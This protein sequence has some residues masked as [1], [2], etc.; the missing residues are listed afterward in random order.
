MIAK[1]LKR[2]LVVLFIVIGVYP[3]FG[4]NNSNHT[5]ISGSVTCQGKGVKNVAVTDGISVVST[6][7]NG[8]YSISTTFDQSHIYYS[9]PANYETPIVDGIP[10][11]YQSVD[12]TK[13]AQVVNFK[14]EKSKRSQ[15]THAFVVW[16][17]PQVYEEAEFDLLDKVVDDLNQS[18]AKLTTSRSVHGICMGD[19]VFD[20]AQFF[21]KYKQQVAKTNIPFYQVIGNHDLDYNNRTN[22][23]SAKTYNSKFGPTYY[24]FN[25]GKIHYVVL[26]DVFYYGYTY[27]YMGYFDETQ[28]R[29]LERDLS[30]VKPGSTVVLSM[31]IPTI[32]GESEKAEKYSTTIANSVMNRSAFYKILAPFNAHL[33][34]GHSHTQWNTI[35]SPTLYEHTHA[36]ACAAWWQGELCVDGSPKGYTVYM[37][38]GDSLSWYFKGVG[39]DKSE[40]FKLYPAGSD[41]LYTDCI[42]ANVF[43]YDPSWQVKWLEDDKLMGEMLQYWGVDPTAKSMYPEGKNKKHSWLSYGETHHLFK[44]KMVNP[45][46]KISVEVIDRFGNKY[47]KT[48]M[49]DNTN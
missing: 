29:W 18:I 12:T 21:D 3:L 34:A 25:V 45:N 42:I 19:I 37:A 22:E 4:F 38:D 30:L 9:L 41:S 2:N 13:H 24:S 32:Y 26:K 39:L 6:D 44:A 7:L 43:N 48:L 27:H 14:L 10:Y 46:A 20:K 5:E 15:T 17:D 35:V 11:F 47:R 40:Q 49:K 1:F 31:H 8:R 23:L 36:A 28:L 16:A 33:M